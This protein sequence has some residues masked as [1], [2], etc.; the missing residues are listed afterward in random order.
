MCL[1]EIDVT[2]NAYEETMKK[3]KS[4]AAQLVEQEQ[5]CIQLMNE[6]LKENS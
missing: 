3:N 2:G 1:N 5:N 6:R 4:L